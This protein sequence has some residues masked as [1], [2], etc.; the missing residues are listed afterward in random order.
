MLRFWFSDRLEV[1]T[2]SLDRLVAGILIEGP[3]TTQSDVNY[4][5]TSP[6]CQLETCIHFLIAN[7]NVMQAVNC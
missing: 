6:C 5:S 4:K 7:Y 1:S 2:G 3:S